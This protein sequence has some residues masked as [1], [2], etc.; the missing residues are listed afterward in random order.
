L[1]LS[2]AVNGER[3]QRRVDRQLD[4]PGVAI[5]ALRLVA[6]DTAGRPLVVDLSGL[7]FIDASC[8]RVLWEVFRVAEEASCMLELAAPQQVVTRVMELWGA[9]WVLGVHDSVAK[10]VIAAAG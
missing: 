1:R 5:L 4:Q 3:H 2:L 10:A 6:L 7:S 8:L 9:D